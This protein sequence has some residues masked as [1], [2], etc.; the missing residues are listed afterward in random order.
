MRGFAGRKN[1]LKLIKFLLKNCEVLNTMIIKFQKKRV[2]K[3]VLME[4]LCKKLS[5]FRR[6]SKTCQIIVL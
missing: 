2:Q 4:K 3:M 1:E 5:V 6:V